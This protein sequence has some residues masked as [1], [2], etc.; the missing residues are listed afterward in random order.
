[1]LKQG[2]VYTVAY[3]R[4][5]YLLVETLKTYNTIDFDLCQTYLQRKMEMISSQTSTS[6]D[7][8]I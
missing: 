1:M 8:E 6:K 5:H 7:L 4:I 3:N 2:D